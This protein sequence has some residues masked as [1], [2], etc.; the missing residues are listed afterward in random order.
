[1]GVIYFCEM[2]RGNSRANLKIDTF[3]F[4]EIEILINPIPAGGPQL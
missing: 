3:P 1:M 4:Q 2:I